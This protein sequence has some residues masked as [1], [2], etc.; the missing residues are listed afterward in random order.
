MAEASEREVEPAEPGTVAATVQM[1]SNARI[2]QNGHLVIDCPIAEIGYGRPH[3]VPLR[4]PL[5]L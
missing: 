4:L 3:T 1:A 2:L 5:R